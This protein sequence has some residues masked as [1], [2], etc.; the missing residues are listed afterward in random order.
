MTSKGK[1][2][3]HAKLSKPTKDVFG[4]VDIGIYG[5][6]CGAIK[7]LADQ[8]A[9]QLSLLAVGYVDADHDW[10]E[11]P[12]KLNR[13]KETFNLEFL[14]QGKQFSFHLNGSQPSPDASP[15]LNKMDVALLNANHF[16]TTCGLL[17]YTPSKESSVR[18]RTS[19]LNHTKWVLGSKEEMPADLQKE[20]PSDVLFFTEDEKDD[21]FNAISSHIAT[22]PIKVLILAGGKSQR[23][24]YDKTVIEHHGKPQWQHMAEIARNFS[25]GVFLSVQ[26]EKELG[27]P[28]LKDTFRG[29]G[30]YGGILTAFQSDPNAAWIVVAADLPF[31]SDDTFRQLIDARRL[32]AYATCF[33]NE[34]TNFPDPLCTLWEPKAYPRLLEYLAGGY[35]CPRKVLINSDVEE[36]MPKDKKWLF[37][38]NTP[39]DLEE[40]QRLAAL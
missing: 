1:H 6:K 10:F 18:K 21:L 28:Q 34:A 8:I 31:V 27:I 9:S 16:D 12:E 15:A 32:S 14:Q 24:G 5:N 39:Q 4:R 26:E 23:M 38:L 25:E 19:H 29:L 17:Y 35:S 2:R 33:H 22:P 11:E 40:F 7:E 37:N 20:L 3:K 30:P 13:S 36:I